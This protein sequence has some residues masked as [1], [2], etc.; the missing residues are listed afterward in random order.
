[1]IL[2]NKLRV[3]L[4]SVVCL[5][6]FYCRQVGQPCKS[7]GDS[8][9]CTQLPGWMATALYRRESIYLIRE[10]E[11]STA[12]MFAF[13]GLTV[14]VLFL[15]ARVGMGC[16]TVLAALSV[17]LYL[18]MRRYVGPNFVTCDEAAHEWIWK[19]SSDAESYVG[20]RASMF[21]IVF[22]VSE[23]FFDSGM[24]TNRRVWCS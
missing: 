20:I 1:M 14:V 19:K 8:D 11:P 12:S 9:A 18:Q 2:V 24:K 4:A 3:L 23:H 7:C 5:L 16:K 21:F 6:Y 17:S 15:F 22:C 10:A 13:L